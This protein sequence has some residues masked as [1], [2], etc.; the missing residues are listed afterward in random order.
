MSL[1]ETPEIDT[2]S[3]VNLGKPFK[4]ILFND[5]N[6]DMMEVVAQI[7]Q[8][9]GYS[10]EQSTRVMMEA[11]NMGRAVVW[12]GHKERCEHVADILEQIR[13]GTKIEPA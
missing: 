13:L 6:H 2:T 1:I 7:A 5:E 10:T 11:N 3:S 12:T 9:T 8:A 4:V